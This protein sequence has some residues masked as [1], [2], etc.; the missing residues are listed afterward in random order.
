MNYGGNILICSIC[1]EYIFITKEEL[2]EHNYNI[3]IYEV[4]C[5][6][7]GYTVKECIDC[8][9]K[10]IKD[11]V[12]STGHTIGEWI[13]DS[14]SN[15]SIDGHM[16]TYCINCDMYFEQ[17]INK[18]G[19]DFTITTTKEA[20]CSEKG[21]YEYYCNRCHEL[22]KVDI[23]KVEHNYKKQIVFGDDYNNIK[24]HYPY[25]MIGNEKEIYT[26]VDC[27]Y[28]K[29]W[30]DTYSGVYMSSASSCAHELS[31]WVIVSEASCESIGLMHKVC[32]KCE[33]IVNLVSSHGGHDYIYHNGK[34]P[35]CLEFGYDEY[36]TCSLCNF[37][38]YEEIEALD[39]DYIEKYRLDATCTSTG[40]VIYE[41]SRDH[42]HQY[43]EDIL[44]GH[45]YHIYYAYISK[46]KY[47]FNADCTLCDKYVSEEIT[48]SLVVTEPATC[49][50]T[51]S[52]YYLVTECENQVFMGYRF[53]TIVSQLDHNY[54]KH[55]VEE[56]TCTSDGYYIYECIDCGSSYDWV[57][58]G[59]CMF[60][61][62]TYTWGD[63]YTTLTAE[64]HCI[65]TC[66]QVETETVSV[67]KVISRKPTCTTVGRYRLTPNR[68]ENWIFSYS[69]TTIEVD[70]LGHDYY[71]E[72]VWGNNY[73]SIT[74][75]IS[76]MR[77]C[78]YSE[79]E[80][81]L[82]EKV[83][84]ENST[85]LEEGSQ[86][87]VS[88][89]FNNSLLETQMIEISVDKLEHIYS[90]VY[91][92]WSS[93]YKYVSG[94]ADCD[95]GCGFT[96]SEVVE[97][98]YRIIEKPTCLENGNG[99]YYTNKFEFDLF[100]E[101]VYGVE[102]VLLGHEYETVYEFNSDYTLLIGKVMC[103]NGCDYKVE[104]TV[105]VDKEVIKEETCVE[106]GYIKY[107]SGLFTNDSF[108]AQ[109]IIVT[110]KEHGHDFSEVVY[111]WNN[112]LTFVSA[113]SVCSYDSNHIETE[114]VEVVSEIILKPTCGSDGVKLYTSNDFSNDA[115]VK[116][117]KEETIEKLG[118]IYGEPI[119]TFDSFTRSFNAVR[120]CINGCGHEESDS[121]ECYIKII[122][123]A[124]C[125]ENGIIAYISKEFKN[126][127]FSAQTYEVSIPAIGHKY[128]NPIY[129]WFEDYSAIRADA[130]CL[131]DS[132]HIIAEIV[133]V[134]GKIVKDPTCMETGIMDCTSMKFKHDVFTTQR[135][136]AE[137]AMVD[138]VYNDVV[139]H[140]TCEQ[141]G[142]TKHICVYC[143]LEYHDSYIPALDH[144][145]VNNHCTR[146]DYVKESNNNPII[147]IVVGILGV[148]SIAVVV[149][150]K[151]KKK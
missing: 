141:E 86:I 40:Y 71:I 95:R 126:E 99:E 30:S 36:Y 144:D 7:D 97:T 65:R 26:C 101:Q 54:Y 31:D 41:C 150:L 85:C 74:A 59:E 102:I 16:H 5:E 28:I 125:T 87:C 108:E 8:G 136:Q 145:I 106:V 93:D 88:K 103:I 9:Y 119:Y 124:T 62:P 53:N 129:D 94:Y 148:L 131:N 84:L 2:K 79:S 142:Y 44:D 110:V 10:V 6:S 13:I 48:V 107:T 128:D 151:F 61:N 60:S 91:Y 70:P 58:T 33:N 11:I 21:I 56:V 4:T 77:N 135:I 49:T 52:G 55:V 66:H 47:K 43:Q 147:V 46:G 149:L 109:S 20:T 121:A 34:N 42:T 76:C 112:D 89:E 39:H 18:L 25:V 1:D 73:D 117:V 75:H 134:S 80:T 138:H 113:S 63:D 12:K 17:T 104:E 123:S 3:N 127:A 143:M 111:N 57:V 82:V 140:P 139:V 81:V 130:V 83:I 22:Y 118:F 24:N 115:F 114:T 120:R 96:H 50:S 132:S 29:K 100:T 27:G 78:G 72:Y 92:E 137:L 14:N 67:T 90:T 32:L 23:P 133:G 116:Q 64:R 98:N 19:H 146:C 15:C 122:S 35:T 51:G 69:T 38:T 37:S 105:G 45:Q 68:F